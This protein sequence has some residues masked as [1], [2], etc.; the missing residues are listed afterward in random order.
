[1]QSGFAF[2][3]LHMHLSKAACAADRLGKQECSGCQ[4]IR[5]FV[6]AI[7]SGLLTPYVYLFLNADESQIGCCCKQTITYV[8]PIPTQLVSSS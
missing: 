1:M 6:L 2:V 7:A 5:P 3:S 8:Q 4:A